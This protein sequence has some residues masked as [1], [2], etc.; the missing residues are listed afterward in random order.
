MPREGPG[1]R[2][3]GETLPDESEPEPGLVHIAIAPGLLDEVLDPGSVASSERTAAVS[4]RSIEAAL[5]D[6]S[7]PDRFEQLVDNLRTNELM[8]FLDPLVA[9][10]GAAGFPRA[11]VRD[12]ALRLAT[13]SGDRNAV[14]V[15]IA[16]LA[17]GAKE[18]DRD[19]LL[20]LGRHEEFTSYVGVTLTA[21]LDDPENS[22]WE[23]A[24]VV[25]LWGRV[26][27]VRELAS[28]TDPEIKAWILRE[29]S[30]G[31]FIIRE[32]AYI[33]ATTGEL[34]AQLRAEKIDEELC[35]C[36]GATLSALI[37]GRQYRYSLDIDDYSGGPEAIRL[38]VSHASRQKERLGSFEA[39]AMIVDF[40][41]LRDCLYHPCATDRHP[42]LR[43]PV[44]WT[45][46]ERTRTATFARWV[47]Q[48]PAW[49]RLAENALR[50]P[51]PWDFAM[52][53]K[54]ARWLG[55]DTMPQMLDRLRH[56]PGD[57]GVWLT[58]V[59][60]ADEKQWQQLLDVATERVLR[61]EGP[62]DRAPPWWIA[63]IQDIERFPGTGW[64]LF[65][66]ALK[67]PI[68]SNR[69]LGLN[70]IETFKAEDW[71]QGADALVRRV[72]RS[73]PDDDL[74]R[75]ATEM[76]AERASGLSRLAPQTPNA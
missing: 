54:A 19:V 25:E 34:L 73:D 10:V 67:S 21:A 29:G 70:G 15:G 40:L 72:A 50:S 44:G 68:A 31:I 58:A 9:K 45:V 37:E 7:A 13:R 56:A 48:R 43:P 60:I 61:D 12:L 38:F 22:L 24:K 6:P 33:A 47:L 32:L 1:L 71:P 53:E 59:R 14:K 66:A 36:A 2:L 4:F 8:G 20:T 26:S 51:H 18:E 30:Q 65:R 3:G 64:L 17:L 52:G 16:L 46:D 55:R 27:I 49:L 63:I 74:R 28:T 57:E 41:E 76:L 42:Y 5:D 75:W 62:D 23:L 69:Q 11:A 39:I 35:R